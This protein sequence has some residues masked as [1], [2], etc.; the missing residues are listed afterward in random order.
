MNPATQKIIEQFNKERN[1]ALLTMDEA[2]IRAYHKKWNPYDRLPNGL[3][4]WRAVHKTITGIQSLP[5]EFRMKSKVWLDEHG[6]RS[7]DDGDL[8]QPQPQPA[9]TPPVATPQATDSGSSTSTPA[10]S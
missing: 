1:E 6:L 10:Q 5:F 8:S 7:F 4:F 2:K 3:T 9:S